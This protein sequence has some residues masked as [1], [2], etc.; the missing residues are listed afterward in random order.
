MGEYPNN[1]TVNI[2]NIYNTQLIYSTSIIPTINNQLIIREDISSILL[3]DTINKFI[4][5]VLLSNNGGEFNN[6]F[7]F[8]KKS[9]TISFHCLLIQVFLDQ[10]LILNQ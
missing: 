7:V 3:P 10:L 9:C 2:L 8:G 5:N 4:I 6:T 1:I